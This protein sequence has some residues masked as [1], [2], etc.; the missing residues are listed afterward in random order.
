MQSVAIFQKSIRD[1]RRNAVASLLS[2][3]TRWTGARDLARIIAILGR[4]ALHK[5]APLRVYWGRAL[6]GAGFRTAVVA[7]R[8]LWTKGLCRVDS[9][10]DETV[11]SGNVV[12]RL[13]R[14]AHYST[15]QKAFQFG[16]HRVSKRSLIIIMPTALLLCCCCCCCAVLAMADIIVL[17]GR[18]SFYPQREKLVAGEL[19]GSACNF[20]LLCDIFH[21]SIIF[22][23]KDLLPFFIDV[24]GLF[25]R[26]RHRYDYSMHGDISQSSHKTTLQNSVD[27]GLGVVDFSGVLGTRY[28]GIKKKE[29]EE[30][31]RE[32]DAREV[33]QDARAPEGDSR[34]LGF[35][36]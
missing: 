18:Y 13:C 19:N 15:W 28:T 6:L 23:C 36:A 24:R 12:G 3:T 14:A 25:L 30:G 10:S 4:N 20:V 26:K 1:A 34:E 9:D 27:N 7:P 11:M 22:H 5:K 33:P 16:T 21:A 31:E 35:I 8:P 2:E 32:R 17:K 29:V